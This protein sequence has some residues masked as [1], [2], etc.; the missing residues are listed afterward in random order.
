MKA[1]DWNTCAL[2]AAGNAVGIPNFVKTP[3]QQLLFAKWPWLV[4]EV[5]QPF[6]PFERIV[7]C[8]ASYYYEGLG[9]P[10][11]PWHGRITRRFDEEVCAGRMTFEQL[12]DYMASIEPEC[13]E[14]NKFVCSCVKAEE[15][16]GWVVEGPAVLVGY[17]EKETW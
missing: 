16:V 4:S 14:C 3:R 15:S 7:Y 11:H 13:G 2:G 9:S 10:W 1:G 8:G 12:V 5:P 6:E 17:K